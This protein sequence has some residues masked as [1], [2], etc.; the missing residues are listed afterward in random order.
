MERRFARGR[1][2]GQLWR[3][4]SSAG[5][6]LGGK[7]PRRRAGHALQPRE[8]SGEQALHRAFD[9][10]RRAA[11]WFARR[12]GYARAPRDSC[13]RRAAAR[14]RAPCAYHA[15]DGGS[16]VG[17]W[18]HAPCRGRSV[19]SCNAQPCGPTGLRESEG[20]ARRVPACARCV[21]VRVEHGAALTGT[22]TCWR[23]P[24]SSG[25]RECG[26]GA[27]ASSGGCRWTGESADGV[28][29]RQRG[30]RCGRPVGSA[31]PGTACCSWK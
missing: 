31:R 18:R 24:P 13:A 17:G 8:R 27:W 21:D 6:A 20:L 2:T 30:P 23:K 19:S 22:K 14:T 5:C 7:R 29:M 25:I 1:I 26:S 28:H 15:H 16:D 3:A 12:C 4:P 10:Q 9:G 11:A